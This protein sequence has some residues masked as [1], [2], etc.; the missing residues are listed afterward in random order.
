MRFATRTFLYSFTPFALLLTGSFWAIQEMVE[1]TVHERL[2][3]ALRDT[4]S[5]IARV[6]SKG[7]LQNS[8][9]LRVIGENAALKAGL[10]LMAVEPQSADA[11]RTVADQLRDV[12]EKL[13]FDLLTVSDTQ[14]KP[15]AGV[16]RSSGR[17]IEMD[18][19]AIQP[20]GRGF[21][22]LE[23]RT[24]QVTSIAL[25]Q[26]DELIGTLA[27][28][29]T[30]DFSG[31]T[32]PAVLTRDG[33]V[34]ISSVPGIATP[35]VE[36]ALKACLP[37]AECKVK[38]GGDTYLSLPLESVTFGDGYV[39]RSLQNVD[40]AIGPVHAILRQ[41]F[42]VAG[43]GALLAAMVVSLLASRSIVKPI[44]SVAEQLRE[45]A[46]T[47]RLPEFQ[48]TPGATYEIREFTRS[49]NRAAASIREARQSLHRAYVE[50]SGSLANALDARD[51]Y[52]AGHSRR[53]SEM[54]C[55]VARAMNFSTEE[56]EEMQIG[57]LLHDIGK[58]GIRDA[59]LQKPGRLTDEEFDL[60][61]QHP[62]I[63]RRIMEGVQGFQPY[64]SIVELH[65][66]NWDGTGY[67]NG[68]LGEETP[69]P[70]RIVHVVDTY[71]AMTTDRPYR[72]GLSHDETLSWL[73]ESA[74]RLFDARVVEVFTQLAPAFARR[75][76]EGFNLE[77]SML[78]LVE[79][80][81]DPPLPARESSEV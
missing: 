65:H 35:L 14:G 28:G 25:E 55:A 2:S 24:Y 77:T 72:N 13:G 46:T 80:V 44:A 53:V 21:L 51:R 10:Q 37:Q 67:P 45:C 34:L 64:L 19:A 30:F 59:V 31:F 52:T 61:K 79:A 57:A 63:G 75:R 76:A 40:S 71:D 54:A 50:F 20:P 29:E 15:L 41:V 68:L 18:T 27:V 1:S 22:N 47:G 8:R 7:E 9:F 42:L 16:I 49:F 69:L 60:I 4:Q 43:L 3:A 70:A 5:T 26:A 36:A 58:I 6:R 11:R 48:T 12:G 32:T 39:L 81:A 78:S 66:E 23:D 17:L 33:R 74:G 56:L 73:Q 62:T 38:L